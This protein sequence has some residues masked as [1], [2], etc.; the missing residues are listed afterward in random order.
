M[1]QEIA[2]SEV[3]RLQR[4]VGDLVSIMALPAMWV[5]CEASQIGGSLL[6]AILAMLDLDVAH[7]HSKNVDGGSALSVTRLSEWTRSIAPSEDFGALFKERIGPEVQAVSS[8]RL[9]D[10]IHQIVSVGLG[11][12]GEMGVIIVGSRR[13]DFPRKTEALLLSVAANQAT[14]GLQAARQ[15]SE[16]KRLARELDERVDQRTSELAAVN[17][18]L[19]RRELDFAHVA[20]VT[21][22]GQ[23]TA[24]IAHEL[25]QPLAGIVTNASTSLRMLTSAQPN[26]AGALE[27]ARRT[28]R[29]ANRAT[30]IVSRLRALFKKHNFAVE[31][32]NLNAATQE[33]LTLTSGKLQR[34]RI[35]L[36]AELD[37]ALPEVRGDRI[38][39]QQVIMNLIVNA[40]EAMEV[41]A[42]RPKELLIA[43]RR[44]EDDHAYVI[45][46]DTGVGFDPKAAE[47]LFQPFHTT[48]S[49]GMGIGLSVSRSIVEHHQGRLWAEANDGPG[50]TFFVAIPTQIN[51]GRTARSQ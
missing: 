9:G 2:I 48:K 20:R 41:V 19:R 29:D 25:N 37:D 50:A 5:G 22:M 31:A 49:D 47:K 10:N 46:R 36:R 42:D 32:V 1:H 26:I 40:V 11:L 38:Q 45:V 7:L 24:S 39:L 35:Q 34:A 51:S 12:F 4:C 8:L 17:E 30:D 44:A 27:T 14:V 13:A 23:L 6:D 33:V 28:I 3:K 18:E 15:L 16:Q 43:T 21:T